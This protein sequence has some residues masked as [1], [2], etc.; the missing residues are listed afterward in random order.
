M[1]IAHPTSFPFS[2]EPWSIILVT[3][4][5]DLTVYSP[6]NGRFKN[7]I[8]SPNF[9][10]QSSK[11]TCTLFSKVSQGFLN[12]L[13]HRGDVSWKCHEWPILGGSSSIQPHT[14]TDVLVTGHSDGMVFFW[15]MSNTHFNLLYSVNILT[16]SEPSS[17]EILSIDLCV[18]SRVLAVSCASGETFVY[19][20]N[21][22][23][24]KIS[25][26][27]KIL[28]TR[29]LEL[30]AQKESNYI[31]ANVA[32]TANPISNPTVSSPEAQ[33]S[34]EVKSNS[35]PAVETKSR[36]VKE[37]T[38]KKERTSQT[39]VFSW[40]KFF[41]NAKIDKKSAAKY[42]EFFEGEKITDDLVK[43]LDQ[44]MMEMAG[45]TTVGDKMRIKKYINNGYNVADCM[46][47]GTSTSTTSSKK[48]SSKKRTKKREKSSRRPMEE[49]ETPKLPAKSSP[50]VSPVREVP[51][52]V[53]PEPEPI[54]PLTELPPGYQLK[55]EC[56]F[57]NRIT[58]IRI[59]SSLSKFVLYLIKK[60]S[61]LIILIFFHK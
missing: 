20:F 16:D 31:I 54:V 45:I 30:Q 38:S 17:P 46:V 11:V 4:N 19:Y 12:D 2:V 53:A 52:Y 33:I 8:P 48:K 3:E 44:D 35:S 40:E 15:D 47:S 42:A 57:R 59:A 1:V 39:M 28:T 24:K 49:T 32:V 21:N 23:P 34:E 10:L 22:T 36:Q 51:V 26:K 13:S 56:S 27:Q 14:S 61:I 58:Q 37:R 50:V 18:E 7:I 41:E 29:A 9:Q 55:T 6:S 25:P 43:D 5:S 60:Y